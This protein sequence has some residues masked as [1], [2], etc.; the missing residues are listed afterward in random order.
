ALPRPE[1]E[2]LWTSGDME[3]VRWVMAAEQ[4]LFFDPANPIADAA[5]L[6]YQAAGRGLLVPIGEE[7]TVGV[8]YLS[9]H[10]RPTPF[11]EGDRVILRTI[12]H[13]AAIAIGTAR[14]HQQIENEA[15]RQ[16]PALPDSEPKTPVS[17][18][19]ASHRPQ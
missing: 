18:T 6:Y 2:K 17:A 3:L 16:P 9:A 19:A 12:A 15:K 4:P 13:A 14:L 10:D 11:E 5:D 8:R 7:G 1:R